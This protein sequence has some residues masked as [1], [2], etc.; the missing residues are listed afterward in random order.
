MVAGKEADGR[1]LATTKEDAGLL[2]VQR[3]RLSLPMPYR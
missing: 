2:G 3:L 1:G